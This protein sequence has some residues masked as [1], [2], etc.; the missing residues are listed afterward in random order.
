MNC[1]IISLDEQKKLPPAVIKW[2]EEYKQIK[3]RHDFYWLE[4]RYLLLSLGY[5]P[6]PGYRL[7]VCKT[8]SGEDGINLI[9]KEQT[10][11]PGMVYPQIIIYPYILLE[12]NQPV[13]IHLISSNEMSQL[14]QYK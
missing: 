2:V 9:V 8:E 5:R 13:N 6:S 14:F 7:D 3:G 11:A 4:K 1:K 12:T 10:P